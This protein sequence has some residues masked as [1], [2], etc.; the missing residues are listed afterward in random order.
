VEFY[1]FAY[2]Y[3][4][5]VKDEIVTTSPAY[6]LVKLKHNVSID[7][8]LP[9]LP[10]SVI[11]IEPELS[12]YNAGRRKKVTFT[13]FPVTLTY[14]IRD[15]KCQSQT[16][17]YVVVDL[18]KPSGR[19]PTSSP[20]VQLSHAQTLNRLSILRPFSDDELKSKLPDELEM[21][22]KWQVQKAKEKE[23]LYI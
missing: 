6:M 5:L 21:E 18:K 16:F 9:G 20:Y 19:S 23:A 8:A 14:A 10:P 15:Y 12:T 4:A 11:G 3:G 1:G 13:Q 2:K 17:R 7:V 22:L